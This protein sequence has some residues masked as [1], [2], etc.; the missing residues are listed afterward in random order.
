LIVVDASAL[1]EVLLRTPTAKTI[2]TRLF[3]SNQTLHA[4][5]LIDIEV[6]QVIR[7]YAA[8]GDIDGDRGEAALTD[9]ADF[10]L[11][12]YPHGVLLRRV[13]ELRHNLTAYDA[14]YVALSE[15][16]DAVLLT[17]DE[18]LATA[19]GHHARIELV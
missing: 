9:L 8:N 7:R 17:R 1:L 13:W 18:R 5:H 11:Q 2:E 19:T 15:A 4:P 6:A 3:A 10:P 14:T 16:L 12:R